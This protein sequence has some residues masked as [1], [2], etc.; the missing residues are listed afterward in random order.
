MSD[1]NI[2]A[3][4]L[5]RFWSTSMVIVA[6]LAMALAWDNHLLKKRIARLMTLLY[7]QSAPSPLQVGDY[8]LELKVKTLT[9]AEQTHSFLDAGQA[10]RRGVMVALLRPNCG[11][12]RKEVPLWNKLAAEDKYKTEFMGVSLGSRAQTEQFMRDEHVTFPVYLGEESLLT[13]F[14]V[15][16]VPVLL[17]MSS[18]GC[19]LEKRIGSK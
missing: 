4:N 3:R 19:I 8:V 16:G 14:H 5:G 6:I 10:D 17:R 2:A 9:G 12:C 7:R 18:D 15:P 1:A 11:Y 13:L